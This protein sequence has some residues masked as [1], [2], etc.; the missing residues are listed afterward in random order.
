MEKGGGRE[1]ENEKNREQ[2]SRRNREK[3]AD[4]S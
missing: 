3:E 2:N 4:I 1:I